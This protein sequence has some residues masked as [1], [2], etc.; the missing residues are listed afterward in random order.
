MSKVIS[1]RYIY[2]RLTDIKGKSHVSQHLVYDAER[3][4]ASQK[5][6]ARNLNDE[7]K[8]DQ[9]RLAKAEQITEEQF[10]NERK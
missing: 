7:V 6:A 3:F 2:M 5:D 8:G 4:V 1:T 10:N 9:P